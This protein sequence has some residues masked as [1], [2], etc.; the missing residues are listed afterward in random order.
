M[1]PIFFCCLLTF[2]FG[3]NF[4]RQ[5]STTA[6]VDN[7]PPF[8]VQLRDSTKFFH[9]NQILSGKAVILLYFDTDCHFCQEETKELVKSMASLKDV[10]LYFLTTS[11]LNE[12][13]KYSADYHLGDYGNIVVARDY[14]YSFY[15]HFKPSEVPYLVIYNKQKEL[16][17]IYKGSV[18]VQAIIDAVHA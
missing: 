6:A 15:K 13:N 11:S 1:K 12:M 14:K 7:L 2:M 16:V 3:C 10:Q 17:K 5:D 4:V 8:E 18:S 9:S